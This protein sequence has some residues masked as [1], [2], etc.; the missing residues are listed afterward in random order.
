MS[1]SDGPVQ[2]SRGPTWPPMLYVA[3]A[4]ATVL[5]VVALALLVTEVRSVLASIFLGFF[6]AA[7]LEP[8]IRKLEARGL[9]RGHAVLVLVTGALILLALIIWLMVVPAVEQASDFVAN[10]PTLLNDLNERG[11]GREILGVKLDD[12]EV[13]RKIQ[14]QVDKIPSILAASLGTVYGILGGIVTAL[15]GIF[16][17]FALTIYFMMAMPRLHS[18]AVRALGDSERVQVLDDSLDR[19]GGYVTGQLVVSLTAGVFSG[20]FL[21]LLG[22]PYSMILGL[23]VAFLDAIPQVGATI[24][25]V[26]CMLV[27]LTESVGLAVVVFLVLLAYQQFENYVLAPRVFSEAVDLSPIAVFV[28]VLVGAAVGGAIGALTALPITA[29]LK[30]VFRYVF[31]EQ[32]GRIDSVAYEGRGV[33][34]DDE[35]EDLP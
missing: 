18:F 3:K 24:G 11:E 31:R 23:A 1:A 12:P 33:Y 27:A 25:A 35:R 6:F 9:R 34:G 5:G 16:T 28:A 14:E 17:V 29:A 19:I 10:I 2:V 8:F 22:V 30:V 20:A 13:Q 21:S 26:L 32:L 4:T 7:G 15:F